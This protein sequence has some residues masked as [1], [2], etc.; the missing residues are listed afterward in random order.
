MMYVINFKTTCNQQV[1][2]IW[3]VWLNQQPAN[4]LQDMRPKYKVRTSA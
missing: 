2:I 1:L 3:I 4:S